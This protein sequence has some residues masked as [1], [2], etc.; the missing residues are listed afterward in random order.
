LT[1]SNVGFKAIIRA[2]PTPIK[3]NNFEH[4]SQLILQ[5]EYIINIEKREANQIVLN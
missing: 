5:K 3:E 1:T 4:S 2:N